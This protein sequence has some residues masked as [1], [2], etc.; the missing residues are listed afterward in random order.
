MWGGKFVGMFMNPAST[1]EDTVPNYFGIFLDVTDEAVLSQPESGSRM[2]DFIM[3]GGTGGVAYHDMMW[4]YTSQSKRPVWI[5]A[6]NYY[7]L[8][9]HKPQPA[10]AMRAMAHEYDNATGTVTLLLSRS[11]RQPETSEL[12]A[13]QMRQ[14][15]RWVMGFLLELGYSTNSIEP[16]YV[17]GWPHN[18]SPYLNGDASW[19]PKLAIDLTNPPPSYSGT[20]ASQYNNQPSV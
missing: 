6:D 15:E 2:S 5:M 8:Y 20:P 16:D 11:L 3:S 19:W 4:V 9:L 17:D 10:F 14:G 1:P 12:N 7:E 18:I 13:L